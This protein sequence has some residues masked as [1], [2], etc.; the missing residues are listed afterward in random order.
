MTG[1]IGKNAGEELSRGDGRAP[2][3]LGPMPWRHR[4]HSDR[5]C[6]SVRERDE[7][8]H[9]DRQATIGHRTQ[10]DGGDAG[11]RCALALHAKG[12]NAIP[13]ADRVEAQRVVADEKQFVGPKVVLRTGQESWLWPGSMVSVAVCSMGACSTRR[14]R[15][16][17]SMARNVPERATRRQDLWPA[18]SVLRFVEQMNNEPSTAAPAA[19]HGPPPTAPHAGLRS[20]PRRR[21][22]PGPRQPALPPGPGWHAPLSMSWHPGPEDA[23]HPPEEMAITW[24]PTSQKL[25]GGLADVRARGTAHDVQQRRRRSAAPRRVCSEHAVAVRWAKATMFGARSSTQ[26]SSSCSSTWCWSPRSRGCR[27]R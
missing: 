9:G 20:C 4:P 19:P 13:D 18:G 17:V 27:R 16:V 12:R 26:P 10:A 14:V 25:D 21:C 1:C 2:G 8:V 6:P 5:R 15:L 7:D 22:R 23:E 11:R 24:G 3:Q